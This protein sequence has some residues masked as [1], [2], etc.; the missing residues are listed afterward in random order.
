LKEVKQVAKKKNLQQEY[1]KLN[2]LNWKTHNDLKHFQADL[3]RM[4]WDYTKMEESS[5]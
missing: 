3:E 5:M 2:K 4:T 1:V